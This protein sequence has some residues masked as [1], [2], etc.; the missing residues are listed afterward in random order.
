LFILWG[1]QTCFSLLIIRRVQ[2]DGNTFQALENRA[3]PF[4]LTNGGNWF[5]LDVRNKA[6]A[7]L[8]PEIVGL[9][10]HNSAV[11]YIPRISIRSIRSPKGSS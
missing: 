6:I 1:L 2:V 10:N 5:L 7:V 8:P 11:I 9:N 3:I 4:N